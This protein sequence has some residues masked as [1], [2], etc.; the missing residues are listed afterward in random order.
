[1]KRFYFRH[2]ILLVAT[3]LFGVHVDLSPIIDLVR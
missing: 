2:A 1:M 3:R